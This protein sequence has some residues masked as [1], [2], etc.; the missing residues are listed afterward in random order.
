MNSPVRRAVVLQLFHEASAISPLQVRRAEF[1]ERHHLRG[2]AVADA[3]RDT[4]NWMGGVLTA[5]DL[6]EM[7]YEIGLCTAAL[8]GGPIAADDFAMLEA[9]LLES[10]D[11]LL[12]EGPVSHVFLLLHGA[13]LAEGCDDPEGDIARAVRER[14]GG[15]ARIAVPLDFHANPGPGLIEAADIV[16]GGKLYPHTD[17]RARGKRLVELALSETDW[18]TVHVPMGLQVPMPRQ[19][20]VD[21]PF[22]ALA[23]LTDRLEGGDIG[24]VTLLG[25]FP[26]SMAPFRGTSLL[27]TTTDKTKAVPVADKVRAAIDE[28]RTALLAPVPGIDDAL[29]AIRDGLSRGRVVIADIGDNPGGGGLGDVTALLP[30]LVSLKRPFAFGFLVAPE[31]V[32][33]ARQA[34]TGSTIG[35]AVP[36][37]TIAAGVA[38]LADIRYRNTGAMMQGEMLYGGPGAVLSIGPSRILVSSLRIQAYDVNAFISQGID[39]EKMDLI[40]VKSIGHF[41][42]SYTPLATGALVL[43]DSG[44]YSSPRRIDAAHGAP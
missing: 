41:R 32:T 11:V 30:A 8:P 38:A 3:F 44:G 14:V 10:L 7:P 36:D 43:V 2:R 31:L 27:V 29:P 4:R 20:T 26:F 33:A 13:L 37:G 22:S 6:A 15:A 5:L 35:I 28:R 39:L 40:A 19:E 16:L 9:E 1:L 23:A 24:D 12:A 17:T 18:K 42:A 21:G 34:G 25:G